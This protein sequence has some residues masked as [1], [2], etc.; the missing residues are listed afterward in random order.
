M[1]E[2]DANTT[3][4][5][6]ASDTQ[7]SAGTSRRNFLK[8]AVV[9]SAA[10]VAVSGAGAAALTL[11]GHHTGLKK[12]VP[13]I[14]DATLSGVTG[15]GCTTDTGDS[16]SDKTAFGPDSIYFWA[17]FNNLPAGQYTIGITIDNG[18]GTN[19]SVDAFHATYGAGMSGVGFQSNAQSVN[20]YALDQKDATFTCHPSTLPDHGNAATSQNSLPVVFSV[21]DGQDALLQLH[22]SPDS[23]DPALTIHMTAS[24][25]T[26]NAVNSANLVDSVTAT[27][28]VS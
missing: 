22:L 15:D 13:F 23:G 9:G 12:Y 2:F 3:P 7:S 26:G 14:G 8:A 16:P 25:Y 27:F 10:A 20:V 18:V 17:K 6:E 11:T 19:L 5:D 4:Y 28:T 24:L 1:D 21:A